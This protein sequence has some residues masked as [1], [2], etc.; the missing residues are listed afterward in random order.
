MLV[1]NAGNGTAG[2]F[3]G[4][5]AADQLGMIDL[6]VRARLRRLLKI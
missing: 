5:D 1:N 4:S 3:D 2:A 6:N